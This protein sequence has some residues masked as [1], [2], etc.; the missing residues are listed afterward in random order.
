MR[1]NITLLNHGLMRTQEANGIAWKM[2]STQTICYVFL[3]ISLDTFEFCSNHME[4]V[5]FAQLSVSSELFFDQEND[6]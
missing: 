6:M 3:F 2:C 1:N 5:F 4:H